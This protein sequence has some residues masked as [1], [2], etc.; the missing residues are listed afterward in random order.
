MTPQHDSPAGWS[1]AD[2]VAY[3]IAQD[4]LTQLIAAAGQQITRL[5]GN[6]DPDPAQIADWQARRATWAQ[7]RLALTPA[8]TSAVRQVLEDDAATLRAIQAS[9]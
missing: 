4:I 8:E 9:S 5:R 3:E 2:G 1:H 6:P 7:R